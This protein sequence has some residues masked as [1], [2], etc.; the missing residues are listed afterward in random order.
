MSEKKGNTEKL[1]YDFNTTEC[2]E[3]QI[4]NSQ[5]C[6]VTPREFR[7]N[8]RPRRI[9]EKTYDG[10]IY[11]YGTNQKVKPENIYKE[12]LLFIHEVDFRNSETKKPF[13]RL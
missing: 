10:P 9:S 3:V 13:G 7:S 2:C 4:S 6:R 11:Y 12:G 1:I 8:S 5:W